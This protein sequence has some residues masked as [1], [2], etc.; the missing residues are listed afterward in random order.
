MKTP[1]NYN[2]IN[3]IDKS[4]VEQ[5]IVKIYREMMKKVYDYDV[6]ALK[7]KTQM[8][9]KDAGLDP[10]S[11]RLCH[12]CYRIKTITHFSLPHNPKE[13]E[14]NVCRNCWVIDKDAAYESQSKYDQT[15]KV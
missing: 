15:K 6:Y 9:Y 10:D 5:T 11:N 2:S 14:Y 7:P 13:K 8:K 3:P 12:M 1:I 4:R